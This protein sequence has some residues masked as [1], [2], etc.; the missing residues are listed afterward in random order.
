[1]T[2]YNYSIDINFFD[3]VYRV[4]NPNNENYSRQD[5]E[6]ILFQLAREKDVT[7]DFSSFIEEDCTIEAVDYLMQKQKGQTA[8]N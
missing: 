2:R 6:S 4:N 3:E 7:T 5:W 8:S 1:M